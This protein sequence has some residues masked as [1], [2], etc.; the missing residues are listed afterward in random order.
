MKQG[1]KVRPSPACLA[2]NPE[3]AGR[4]GIVVEVG[5]GVEVMW[6]GSD[7]SVWLKK[8]HVVATD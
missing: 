6:D 1:S 7:L 4:R 8:E 2:E 5:E 3:L